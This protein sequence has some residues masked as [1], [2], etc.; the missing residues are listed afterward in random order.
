MSEMPSQR[1]ACIYPTPCSS[2]MMTRTALA[3]DGRAQWQRRSISSADGA[4]MARNRFVVD[5]A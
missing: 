5:Q 4:P 3:G 2:A 1:S